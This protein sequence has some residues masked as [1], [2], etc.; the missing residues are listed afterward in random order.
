MYRLKMKLKLIGLLL[1]IFL[2]AGCIKTGSLYKEKVCDSVA[3]C[4]CGVHVKT[5]DCFYGNKAYVDTEK[6]CP[7]F[8]TGIAGNFELRCINSQCVSVPKEQEDFCGVSSFSSCQSSSDCVTGG[9][10]GQFC[11]SKADE[12]IITTC[13]F[14]ECYDEALYNLKCVCFE[15]K[16]QWR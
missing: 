1:V 3:D 8:C 12:P 6:Q 7:D 10:S 15:N 9:C 14:K 11:Q 5:G 2:T 16:C 4:A 13:E